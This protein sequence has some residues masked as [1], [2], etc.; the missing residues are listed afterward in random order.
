MP[1]AFQVYV[2]AK[3]TDA[4]AALVGL[5][6]RGLSESPGSEWVRLDGRDEA[7]ALGRRASDVVQGEAVSIEGHTASG[8]EFVV[9]KRGETIRS[10]AHDGTWRVSG[11]PQPWEATLFDGDDAPD[12]DDAA[13]KRALAKK[14]LVDGARFPPAGLERLLRARGLPEAHTFVVDA[15]LAHRGSWRE[16]MIAWLVGGIVLLVL[17][18]LFLEPS[19]VSSAIVFG[20]TLVPWIVGLKYLQHENGGH[21]ITASRTW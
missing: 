10:I 12:E 20:V 13:G 21:S 16:M 15:P 11:N 2:R 3:G 14:R 8:F 1:A 9:H 18:G 5:G 6:H 4:R 7:H 19:S 17:E